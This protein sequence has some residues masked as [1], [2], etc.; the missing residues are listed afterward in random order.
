MR[1]FLRPVV[2]L[3]VTHLLICGS[4]LALDDS[5]LQIQYMESLRLEDDPN[6]A[7]H[8]YRADAG[9]SPGS[10]LITSAHVASVTSLTGE[11]VATC[12]ATYGMAPAPLPAGTV[13]VGGMSATFGCDKPV[14]LSEKYPERQ[15]FQLAITYGTGTSV[16][17][18]V[19]KW[20]IVHDKQSRNQWGQARPHGTR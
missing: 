13:A 6:Q 14:K 12:T 10:P 18:G 11:K 20:L 2:G 4:A 9:Q 15:F 3:F 7:V 16:A 8:L 17:P 1:K 5:A 19:A